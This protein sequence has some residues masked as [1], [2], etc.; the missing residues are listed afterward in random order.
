MRA[1][2]WKVALPA[3][4]SAAGQDQPPTRHGLELHSLGVLPASETLTQ[5]PVL[6]CRDHSSDV[7]SLQR[8]QPGSRI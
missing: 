3:L 8:G 7:I 2:I 5:P 1:Q 6:T 4:T